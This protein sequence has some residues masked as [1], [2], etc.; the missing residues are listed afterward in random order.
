MYVYIYI[1]INHISQDSKNL[2]IAA[3]SLHAIKTITI[4]QKYLYY[5]R[6]PTLLLHAKQKVTLHKN[7]L[8]QN[9]SQNLSKRIIINHYKS[10][11]DISRHPTDLMILTTKERKTFCLGLQTSLQKQQ[12]IYS[13][14]NQKH[15]KHQQTKQQPKNNNNNNNQGKL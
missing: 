2:F 5:P 15:S 8:G 13:S 6:Q 10:I 9:S 11:K 1:R 12:Q 4:M 3:C 7:N 14:P